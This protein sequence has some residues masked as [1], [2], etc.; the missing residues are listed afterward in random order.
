MNVTLLVLREPADR[1]ISAFHYAKHGSDLMPR[2]TQHMA[3]IASLFATTGG[4]V[5]ALRHESR[6]VV[7]GNILVEP[8]DRPNDTLSSAAWKLLVHR[9]GGVQ[10]RATSWWL[11]ASY[12][13]HRAVACYTSSPALL[14]RRVRSALERHNISCSFANVLRHN[15]PMAGSSVNG[16]RT[17]TLAQL[18]WVRTLYAADWRLWKTH[19]G[20]HT[21]TN[22]GSS[23]KMKADKT[24][25]L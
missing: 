22:L 7:F 10:F 24:Q 3:A 15:S 21:V 9:E 14:A 16:T 20:R 8:G 4:F 12:E 25:L 23:R 13:R 17:L 18:E 5:E 1:F 19:C 11:D 6:R 2:D